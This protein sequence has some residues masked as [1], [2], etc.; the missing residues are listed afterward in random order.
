MY[1]V[2]IS[3]WILEQK[4]FLY[5]YFLIGFHIIYLK[6]KIVRFLNWALFSLIFSEL[7]Q[8]K[9]VYVD[10]FFNLE[11]SNAIFVLP[12]WF[13]K[14]RDQKQLYR[15]NE[16]KSHS[17][18]HSIG[19]RSSMSSVLWGTWTFEQPARFVTYVQVPHNI[20][21]IELLLPI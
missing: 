10:K 14:A 17:R 8:N 20:E 19:R 4:I 2:Y 3:R 18:G 21:N 9:I 1:I 5:K 6:S 12:H 16:T 13:H 7:S 15:L 11:H